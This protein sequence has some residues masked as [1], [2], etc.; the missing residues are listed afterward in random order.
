MLKKIIEDL[1]SILE[2]ENCETN[3][4]KFEHKIKN[5]NYLNIIFSKKDELIKLT[6]ELILKY[7]NQSP[8]LTKKPNIIKRNFLNYSIKSKINEEDIE[9]YESLNKILDLS[10]LNQ[11][12]KMPYKQL[13]FSFISTYFGINNKFPDYVNKIGIALLITSLSSAIMVMNKM[14]KQY[15]NLKKCQNNL[16]NLQDKINK[17]IDLKEEYKK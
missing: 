17:Y 9:L 13:L 6:N 1:D 12:I 11:N 14:N 7:E 2:D 10:Y 15:E 3:I 5:D 8:F 4:K 16:L